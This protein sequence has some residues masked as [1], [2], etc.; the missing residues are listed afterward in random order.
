MLVKRLVDFKYGVFTIFAPPDRILNVGSASLLI[1]GYNQTTI[2]DVLLFHIAANTIEVDIR[3]PSNCGKSLIMLNE[4]LTINQESSTTECVGMEVLQVG[5]GNTAS[6]SAPK[7][8]GK[9]VQAC[10]GVVYTIE[11]ALLLP[12]LPNFTDSSGDN[13]DIPGTAVDAGLFNILVAA[14]GAADLVDA[15]TEPNGP[16]TVFA[17]TDD[18]FASLPDGLVTC[19]L[20]EENKGALSSILLYH[21]VSG[22]VLSTDLMDGMEAPTLEGEFVIVDLTDDVMINNSTVLVVDVV[23][24]NGVIHIID[25][26]LVPPSIDIPAFLSTCDA[27]DAAPTQSM[28]TTDLSPGAAPTQPV[29]G[30]P[31]IPNPPFIAPTLEVDGEEDVAD[32]GGNYLL[33]LNQSLFIAVSTLFLF[34]SF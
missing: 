2:N 28:P 24:T 16:F 22:K 31:S 17:P 13:L 25:Q 18:A 15:L 8:V 21:V 32:S 14:L 12:T 34:S 27:S 9:A 3:D 10:N 7:I 29:A 1:D 30:E 20:K 5:P 6:G 33:C 11:D 19:L 26:V 23:A 4:D